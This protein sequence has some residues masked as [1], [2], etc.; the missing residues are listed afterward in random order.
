MNTTDE[1]ATY[2]GG[3]SDY[4]DDTDVSDSIESPDPF[5]N[6]VLKMDKVPVYLIC[7]KWDIAT[8][9]KNIDVFI[10]LYKNNVIK[11]ALRLFSIQIS[12]GSFIPAERLYYF[13]MKAGHIG[14]RL[15]HYEKDRMRVFM[16]VKESCQSCFYNINQISISVHMPTFDRGMKHI[17]ACLEMLRYLRILYCYNVYVVDQ[18]S[19]DLWCR[20]QLD[21]PTKKRKNKPLI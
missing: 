5:A 9:M 8:F 15:V 17:T 6:R 21:R 14:L 2:W 13:S 19:D 11:K 7:D 3:Y 1:I 16:H 18:V 20:V 10:E 12:N 4:S